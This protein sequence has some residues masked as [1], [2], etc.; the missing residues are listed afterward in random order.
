MKVEAGDQ[1][2]TTKP[3]RPFKPKVRTGCITC[4]IRHVKC[5][6]K[7]PEC[8]RCTSTG[9]KCDG[10]APPKTLMFEICDD[11]RERRSFHYFR[12]RTTLEICSYDVSTFWSTLVLQAG[13]A[14]EPVRYAIV[15][16][17]SFH[18]SLESKQDLQRISQSRFTLEQYNKA[19]KA[20]TKDAKTLGIEEVLVSCIIFV[21]FENIQGHFDTALKH[22]GNGLKILSEWRAG[23]R[24]GR[25]CPSPV[26]EDEL[27]GILDTL[28]VQ[29]SVLLP[30]SR[31]NMR[32]RYS[33]KLPASFADLQQ[34][35][36]YFYQLVHWTCENLEM[37]VDEDNP[38]GIR[39]S[40]IAPQCATKFVQYYSLLD[41]DIIGIIKK[42]NASLQ[43]TI[44]TKLGV[45]HL[46]IQYHIV[47]IMLR[48]L[49][50]KN[51]TVFDQQLHHF[52]A[53]LELVRHFFKLAKTPSFN[54]GSAKKVTGF[55]FFII[56]S[57]SMVGC[58][59]RDPL[60]RREAIALLRSAHWREDIWDS[61]DASSVVE[62]M[63]LA[64][65]KGRDVNTCSEIPDFDR[66]HLVGCTSFSYSKEARSLELQPHHT[67]DPEWV[68]MTCVRS[69]WDGVRDGV[70]DIWFNR[71]GDASIAIQPGFFP[72]DVDG[73][74]PQIV[75]KDSQLF[76]LLS[77]GNAAR[78]M[79]RFHANNMFAT[80]HTR[81]TG[82]HSDFVTLSGEFTEYL[83]TDKHRYELN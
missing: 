74:F 24:S 79:G 58:R 68:K 25:I 62:Q 1:L 70:E 7:K 37:P 45:L 12:E 2:A 11:D 38:M 61:I 16:I 67:F 71:H 5:D 18:E 9:R 10:F 26:V 54:F 21:F 36:H 41:G 52:K 75:R 39:D 50:F 83:A 65:E 35:H 30:G 55:D 80:E 82:R 76:S 27:A 64:E 60:I 48:C 56:P 57:L 14:H 17:G 53:I 20:L 49:P 15:A 73:L 32:K 81:G 22:L 31:S 72:R 42:N 4:K 66:L 28:H 59:C 77:T 33:D 29:A 63:V 43:E 47:I 51:E 6:E 23:R 44:A 46:K 69:G 8:L 19:M 3:K 34:A 40:F 13:Y 78:F